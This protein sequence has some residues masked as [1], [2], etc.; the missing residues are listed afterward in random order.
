[1]RTQNQLATMATRGVS[2]GRS[3]LQRKC[4][5]G[6]SS[7]RPGKPCHGCANDDL[8]VQRRA[9]NE[10]SPFTIPPSVHAV[11]RSS[12]QPLDGQTRTLMEANF[13]H[14]FERIPIHPVGLEMAQSGNSHSE[15]TYERQAD[16]VAEQV[17]TAGEASRRNGASRTPF[18]YD[19]SQVRIH[20]DVRAA[21]SA[22]SV[23]ASAYTVGHDIVFD[24]G[25][26]RPGTREGR[27][28]LAHELTHVVQQQAGSRPQVQRQEKKGTK[29]QEW[30]KDRDGELYYESEAKA[31]QRM[32]KLEEEGAW[33]EYRV[34]SFSVKGKKFWRVEMRGPK[35]AG[36]AK[37]KAPLETEAP[38]KKGDKKTTEPKGEEKPAAPKKEDKGAAA[39]GDK[40]AKAPEKA[41]KGAG[42]VCLT[43]DDG[44]QPG[45][46]DVLDVLKGKSAPATFFLTGKN[47]EGD[48]TTQKALVERTL[49]EGHQIGNHTFT[50]DPMTVK[51]YEKAYGDL[52]DP[53]KLKKFEKNYEDNRKHFEKLMG[54]KFPGFKMARLPASGRFV[55]A[56]GKLIMVVATEGMGLAHVTWHFEFAPNG[57]FGHLKFTDWKGVKGVAAEVDQLPAAND[58]VLFHDRHWAGGNKSKLTATLTKL[59]TEGFK[60]GK[61]DSSGKCG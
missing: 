4:A 12:G 42:K 38:P 23:N 52:S 44:P 37:K 24:V 46:G 61:L 2:A 17:L 25:E 34:T 48:P 28:L 10:D 35:K 51:E 14:S 29:K 1:M 27:R 7:E 5:C 60:F 6:A 31:E 47:M 20:T 41:A 32:D 11:L 16:R 56:H 30:V 39:K 8:T 40:E 9:G 18:T 15:Q 49:K 59:E 22:R 3:C 50:H 57:V 54:P 55:K 33:S 19:F 13:S 43:F 26:Y 36:E 45:T 21:E 58:V 53:E